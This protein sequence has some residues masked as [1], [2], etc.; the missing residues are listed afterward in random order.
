MTT[1]VHGSKVGDSILVGHNIKSCDIPHI[2]RAAKR[3]GVSFDNTYFDTKL[4]AKS[5]KDKY[6]WEKITLPYLSKYY[7]IKQEEA[8][9]AWCD[10]EANAYVYMELKKGDGYRCKSTDGS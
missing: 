2:V 3:A 8:H 5:L 1:L 6:G 4:L 7:N 10:A 9:R